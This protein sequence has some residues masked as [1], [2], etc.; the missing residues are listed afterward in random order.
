LQNRYI[1]IIYFSYFLLISFSNTVLRIKN[2][3]YK[4]LHILNNLQNKLKVHCKKELESI[5]K[6]LNK[7]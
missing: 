7:F 1:Q 4:K 2:Y 5:K 6:Y 3:F